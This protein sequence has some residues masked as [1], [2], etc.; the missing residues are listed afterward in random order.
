VISISFPAIAHYD[1]SQQCTSYQTEIFWPLNYSEFVESCKHV[2]AIS[3]SMRVRKRP[4]DVRK[5]S[6]YS[7]NLRWRMV[8]QRE[9][10]GLSLQ[11][12]AGNLGVNPS[13]VSRV[14]SLFKATEDA[15]PNKKLSK[16]VQLTFTRYCNAQESN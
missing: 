12:V 7:N 1:S 2:R 15:R 10:L 13:T 11:T 6:A 3:L 14:V 4:N 8:W 16:T 9:G 5:T